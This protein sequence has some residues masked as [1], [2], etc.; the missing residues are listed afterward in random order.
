MRYRKT[1]LVALILVCSL[2]AGAGVALGDMFQYGDFSHFSVWNPQGASQVTNNWGQPGGDVADLKYGSVSQ[3]I[4]C[5]VG[6]QYELT[7]CFAAK[8]GE[9]GNCGVTVA[10]GDVLSKDFTC[11]NSQGWVTEKCVFTCDNK[12]ELCTFECKGFPC[13]T[14]ICECHCN[15]V[16]EPASLVVWGLLGAGFCGFNVLR[17]RGMTGGAKSSRAWSPAQREAIQRIILGSQQHV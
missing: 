9:T 4:S 3:T 15:A 5:T 2:G 8:P 13:D 7:F 11:T 1:A 17:R 10:C 16:P 6:K 14:C 12:N